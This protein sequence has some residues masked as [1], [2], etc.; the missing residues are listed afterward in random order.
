M[1]ESRLIHADV[2]E[3]TQ[4]E[5]DETGPEKRQELAICV[6]AEC[7][8]AARP[9]AVSTRAVD[10]PHHVTFAQA[11]GRRGEAKRQIP[12]NDRAAVRR[13]IEVKRRS[14]CFEHDRLADGEKA[15]CPK[16]AH[17]DAGERIS[18]C[19]IPERRHQCGIGRKRRW[20]A[21]CARTT[22]KGQEKR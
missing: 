2:A 16:I 17:V 10:E 12:L 21:G 9:A 19:F 13:L 22:G 14:P 11:P 5:A 20:R 15:A 18:G 7:P 8:Q 4:F 1:S 3:M 6:G